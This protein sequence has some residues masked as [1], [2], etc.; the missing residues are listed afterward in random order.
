MVHW[1]HRVAR[2]SRQLT[3][4]SAAAAGDDSSSS[5]QQ[6]WKL[7]YWPATTQ[8]G[9]ILAGA[10]RGEYVRV[11]FEEA[12]VE[13]EEVSDPQVLREFFGMDAAAT[14]TS[15]PLLAPPAIVS[16]DGSFQMAQTAD[17]ARY[18]GK[19]FGLFPPASNP[20]QQARADQILSTVH[21]YIAEGRLSFHPVKNTMSYFDQVQ[22]AAPYI[23]AFVT[24]R[25]PRYLAHFEALLDYASASSSGGEAAQERYFVGGAV[26]VVD[27]QVW[28]M[29][30]VTEQQVRH[31]THS[32][33]LLATIDLNRI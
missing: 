6:H 10:G 13:Y 18:L 33:R 27:L 15:F 9:K 4:C 29:L 2:V 26:S 7:M 1:Q 23:R 20:E 31:P 22:E 21:E 14:N 24:E 17:I 19:K 32:R 25:G 3:P 12:G 5:S 8:D 11:V 16:P 28:V 30:D